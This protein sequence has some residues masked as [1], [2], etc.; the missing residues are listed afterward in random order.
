MVSKAIAILVDGEWW[1]KSRILVGIDVPFL[2]KDEYKDR[3]L[4][5]EIQRAW[6]KD[7]RDLLLSITHSYF[8]C[9]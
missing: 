4:H 9:E 2:L 3:P 6:L 5:S 8:T 1:F 7:E